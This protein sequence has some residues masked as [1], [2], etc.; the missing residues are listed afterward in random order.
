MHKFIFSSLLIILTF[1]ATAQNA[2]EKA[3]KAILDNQ[4]QAWNAGD[5]EKFMIGYWNNDSLMFIGSNG[6][7]YGYA[8]TLANYKKVIRILLTW[9]SLLLR[10]SA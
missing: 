5:L 7:T 6:P 10:L 1:T 9:A 8:K 3:I 2:D 4:Q